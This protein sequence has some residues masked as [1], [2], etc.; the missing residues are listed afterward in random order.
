MGFV[1][2]VVPINNP[3]CTPTAQ[4]VITSYPRIKRTSRSSAKRV[5]A[6]PNIMH[7]VIN[8]YIPWNI[9]K[10]TVHTKPNVIG[11]YT[12]ICLYIYTYII[13]YIPIYTYIYLYI[14]SNHPRPA[15]R[16]C[17]AMADPFGRARDAVQGWVK[18]LHSPKIIDFIHEMIDFILEIV[19]LGDKTTCESRRT[20]ADLRM[21]WATLFWHTFSH[22]HTRTELDHWSDPLGT[23]SRK[24]AIKP[25]EWCKVDLH[26]AVFNL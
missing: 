9:K 17:Q 19:D 5:Q 3:K 1:T 4:E 8:H 6:H 18:R 16:S 23:E 25:D 7:L 12:Y 2:I 22:T 26:V 13:V 24:R 20:I 14:P 15:T 11:L 21:N 10:K